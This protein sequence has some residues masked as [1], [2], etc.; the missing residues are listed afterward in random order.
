MVTMLSNRKIKPVTPGELLKKEF[1]DPMSIS[2][3]QLAKELAVP[4]RYIND[5]ILGKCAITA[6][7][8]LRLC[9]YFELSSGYWLR[10]QAAQDRVNS[11]ATSD[12]QII[13]VAVKEKK[14]G[15]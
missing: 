4:E 3:N 14:I 15:K 10:A 5:I 9:E 1:L 6:D 2:I 7:T 12:K 8:D 11:Q 13:Q